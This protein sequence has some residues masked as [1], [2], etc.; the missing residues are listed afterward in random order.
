MK[1]H[2]K[3]AF[4]LFGLLLVVA[5]TI[6]AAT[7]PSPEVN[8]ATTS[9]TLVVRVVGETPHVE[10]TN[11]TDDE[12]F[13]TPVHSFEYIY[14]NVE[15][16]TIIL[17]YTDTDGVTHE[18]VLESIDADYYPG[19]G[20]IDLDLSDPEYGYGDYV[21][22]ITGDHQ[23]AASD[24]DSYSFSYYPFTAEVE[25]DDE[26]DNANVILD[27]DDSTEIERIEIVVLDENGNPVPDLPTITVT[28][29]EK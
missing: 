29:P 3:K 26:T 2:T 4:G 17:E 5:T 11:L 15:T 19:S 10:F 24:E 7:L 16:V 25:E 23:I 14:D 20:T 12:T 13:L 6:F 8:A 28:P 9:D 1:K 21:I 18:Y 27:Y 22:R